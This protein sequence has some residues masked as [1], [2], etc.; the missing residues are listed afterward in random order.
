MQKKVFILFFACAAWCAAGAQEPN[1]T[2]THQWPQSEQRQLPQAQVENGVPVYKV[3]VV[4]RDIPAVNYFHRSG[5]T[6]I[7]F[8]G[9]SL[10]P[11]ARGEASVESFKGRMSIHVKL[12]DLIPAN[13]FGIEYLTYVLWAITPEG[14]P[15]NLGEILPDGS[16]CDIT[17]TTDLQSFGLIVTAEP[18]FAVTMPS[19]VV[20]IQNEIIH[21]KTTGILETVNAHYSLLPRGAYTQIAGRHAVL[22]PI[23]RNDRSPLE[24]YEAI[25]AVQIAEADGAAQYARDTLATAQQD[26]QNAQAMDTHKGN[27]KEEITYAREAVQT[28][29]DARIETIRK[30]REEDEARHKQQAEEAQQQAQQSA[31]QAQEAAAQRAKAEADAAT[32]QAE[33]ER[34][35][36]QREAAE[37]QARE[38]SQQAQQASQQTEQMRE[39]LRQQLNQVLATQ[40]TAR[41][42]I[43]N[44]S[45]VL[46][47]FNKYTLKQD[48]QVRLARVAGILLTY[49]D[50]KLQVEGYT[51]NI[52]SDAYNQKLSQQ[53]ADAVRDFLVAQGVQLANITSTGYGMAQPVADNATSAGRAKNRR[54]QLVVSGHAIGVQEQA[55]T[56]QNSQPLAAP[57]P[58]QPQ[59]QAPA[60]PQSNSGVSNVPPS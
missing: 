21:D 10:L 26:L 54:V 27:S 7:A 8:E 11:Q 30:K 32:A 46:F 13:N 50:L 43:V 4:G 49:P 20:V 56:Q 14:R 22:H 15:V 45:D 12:R 5:S 23:T 3:T 55:P 36:A 31:L 39:R 16:K 37:A 6:K 1:P 47:D 41:G 57:P 38:A 28:A 40:E 53:R 35:R 48:A 25:N 18:Y 51:D 59:S 52:G 44:M 17:V 60:P 9:T 58:A 42:L 29:E 19:D 34:A 33:A 2:S 24:L